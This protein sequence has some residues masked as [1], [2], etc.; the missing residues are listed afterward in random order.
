MDA[1][2]EAEDAL[3]EVLDDIWVPDE[4]NCVRMRLEG[5]TKN[6]V[7][8]LEGATE[9]RVEF[10]AFIGQ[11]SQELERESGGKLPPG[12]RAAITFEDVLEVGDTVETEGRTFE[13][14]RLAPIRL[15]DSIA[16]DATLEEVASG[17]RA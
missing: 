4:P 14:K 13:V 1:L 6:A 16:Y 8:E 5:G 2:T 7:G 15:H 12:R 17:S 10:A 11:V 3:R 9:E